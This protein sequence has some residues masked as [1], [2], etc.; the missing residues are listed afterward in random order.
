MHTEVGAQTT[1]VETEFVHHN[2]PRADGVNARAAVASG[3]SLENPYRQNSPPWIL[4][5]RA[6]SLEEDANW[7]GNEA[8]QQEQRARASAKLSH[9]LRQQAAEMRL[10]ASRL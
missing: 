4:I 6:L 3:T 1:K 5:E 7:A 9:E 8:Q 2:S 10:A